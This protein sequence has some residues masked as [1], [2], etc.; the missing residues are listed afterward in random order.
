MPQRPRYLVFLLLSWI[1]LTGLAQKQI[2]QFSG[3]IRDVESSS[4]VPYAA[5]YIQ[6]KN[7]GTISGPDGFFTFAAAKGDTILIKSLGYKP[8]KVVIPQ[9]I[10][11]TSF[12]REILL[13]RDVIELKG[14]TIRP[15]PEPSQ[16]RQ[17]MINLDIP[18]NMA[19]LAQQTIANSIIDDEIERNTR[20]DGAENYNQYVKQQTQYYYNRFG[21][22]RPGIS[23]TNPFAWAEFIKAI[24]NGDFK[25][26]K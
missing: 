7:Q 23:L 24:K 11:G 3:F 25:R 15:L 21:N 1:S 12:S 17:A 16:L 2:V 6:D 26:K 8:F 13:E 19:E 10:E 22:Q 9:D 14:V 18:D 5:V 4:I 20:Y